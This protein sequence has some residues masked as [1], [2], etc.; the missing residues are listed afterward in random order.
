MTARFPDGETCP[1]CRADDAEDPIIRLNCLHAVHQPCLESLQ[2][3]SQCA[4]ADVKCPICRKSANDLANMEHELQRPDRP[5][6]IPLGA[7]L[8]QIDSS[9][10]LEPAADVAGPEAGH[11]DAVVEPPFGEPEQSVDSVEPPLVELQ[12]GPAHAP[13]AVPIAEPET[14]VLARE[15]PMVDAIS[16]PLADTLVGEVRERAATEAPPAPKAPPATPALYDPPEHF[17]R[18]AVSEPALPNETL[19]CN[20]CNL[21]V[22]KSKARMQSKGSAKCKCDRCNST[23]VKLNKALGQWPTPAFNVLSA[24]DQAEFYAKA[25]KEAKTANVVTLLE[26]SLTKFKKKE[27]SWALGGEFLPLS[28]WKVKGFDPERIAATT[29]PEDIQENEQAGTCYRVRIYS[30]Q[31]AGAEGFV[32]S[33]RLSSASGDGDRNLGADMWTRNT[34]PRL[35]QASSSSGETRAEFNDRMKR[36]K[37]ERKEI[38]KKLCQTKLMANQLSKK[39]A[40]PLL[41]LSSLLNEAE[42]HIPGSVANCAKAKRDEAAA[43][44]MSLNAIVANPESAPFDPAIKKEVIACRVGLAKSFA[45]RA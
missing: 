32:A 15:H 2:E 26:F 3:A 37:A 31:E 5:M 11:V 43:L 12:G 36:E 22:D 7:Q 20:W 8:Q 41:H 27:F 38:E 35:E 13:I 10:E 45:V 25:A 34:R 28:V 9:P 33:Q 16:P 1:I 6:R 14:P 42:T 40:A 39:L 19:F 29:K 21:P 30:T 4:Y 24:E 23:F 18:A 17:Q 44:Q